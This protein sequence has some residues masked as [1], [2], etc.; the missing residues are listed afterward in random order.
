MSVLN[1]RQYQKKVLR[2]MS[3]QV[4]SG[5]EFAVHRPQR[6]PVLPKFDTHLRGIVPSKSDWVLCV[7]SL[8]ERAY[9]LLCY[10]TYAD[11]YLRTGRAISRP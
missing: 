4:F 5:M 3:Y 8:I 11:G 9:T 6:P 1:Y 10:P 7:P 2:R